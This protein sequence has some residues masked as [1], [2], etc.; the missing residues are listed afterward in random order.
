MGRRKEHQL[1]DDNKPSLATQ[2]RPRFFRRGTLFL[3]TTIKS[4]E[5]MIPVVKGEGLKPHVEIKET[6]GE[7]RYVNKVGAIAEDAAQAD[8]IEKKMEDLGNRLG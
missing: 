2:V 5:D 7:S 8:R 1:L 3:A 6:P 4:I